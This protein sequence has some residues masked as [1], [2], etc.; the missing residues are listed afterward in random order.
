MTRI[1]SK[2]SQ[3][4]L[5]FSYLAVLRWSCN[6]NCLKLGT[7]R[8]EASR[9][10]VPPVRQGHSQGHSDTQIQLDRRRPEIR[11]HLFAKDTPTPR[12]SSSGAQDPKTKTASANTQT[13]NR[14]LWLSPYTF[15][16][17]PPRTSRE[18]SATQRSEKRA[19]LRRPRGPQSHSGTE[20][21]S[22]DLKL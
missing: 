16:L 21:P 7:A 18:V 3:L 2:T 14:G 15:N 1:A 19:H 22:I 4:C 8:Q 11:F 5:F 6:S 9:D 17:T 20:R 12:Y 10:P 13:V